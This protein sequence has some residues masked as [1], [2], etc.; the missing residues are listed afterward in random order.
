MLGSVKIRFRAMARAFDR[1]GRFV[2]GQIEGSVE[3]KL[4]KRRQ[5][6]L[7]RLNYAYAMAANSNL[8]YPLDLWR[9]HRAQP[10]E[11]TCELLSG[12]LEEGC[13]PDVLADFQARY[14]VAPRLN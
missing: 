4:E 8:R 2:A 6:A 12:P 14:A 3:A 1:L 7:K 5:P 13:G 11:F 9:D 10:C